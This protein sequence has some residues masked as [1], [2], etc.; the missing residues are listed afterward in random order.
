MSWKKGL[1][2]DSLLYLVLDKDICPK[3]KIDNV[4]SQAG[5]SGINLL[6]LR[7]NNADDEEFLKDAASVSKACKKQGLVFLVNNR[8]DIALVVD[9]DGVHLGQSDLPVTE[10]RKILGKNKIIG[11]TCRNLIQAQKAEAQGADYISIGPIFSTPIKPD[12]KPIKK[13]LIGVINR[14]LSIPVFGIG[15]INATN[16]KQ[17]FFYGVKRFAVS[18]AICQSKCVKQ[19]VC[20]LRCEIS[21]SRNFNH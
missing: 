9:A 1:L 17:A 5:K 15:G 14:K 20:N 8:L 6:Q 19:A 7:E 2:L 10:A 21:K 16:I 3:G 18:R 13:E 4:L 12:L 11:L